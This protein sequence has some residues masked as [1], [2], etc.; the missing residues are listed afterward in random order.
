[1]AGFIMMFLPRIANS[2]AVQHRSTSQNLVSGQ[3][4][5]AV[6]QE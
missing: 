1:M 4:Q 2:W 3:K 5:V 6:N